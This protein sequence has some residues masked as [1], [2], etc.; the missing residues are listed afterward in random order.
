M[1]FVPARASTTIRKPK[2]T[3]KVKIGT[4]SGVWPVGVRTWLSAVAMPK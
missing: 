4:P 3:G 1:R 2:C